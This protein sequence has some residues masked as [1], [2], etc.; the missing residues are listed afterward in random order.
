MIFASGMRLTP[1][2]LSVPTGRVTVTGGPATVIDT[3]VAFGWTFAT[4]PRVGAN[5]AGAAT[6]NADVRAV[7]VTTTGFTLRVYGV[8][9]ASIT[10]AAVVVDWWANPA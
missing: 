9:G 10:L 4:P 3:A 1:A 2:R 5:I 7:D 8:A 6:T